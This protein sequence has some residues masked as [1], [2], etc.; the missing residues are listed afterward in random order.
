MEIWIIVFL[1]VWVLANV[2]WNYRMFSNN[3][4]VCIGA[5]FQG[6]FAAVPN[7]VVIFSEWMTEKFEFWTFPIFMSKELREDVA[8]VNEQYPNNIMVIHEADGKEVHF[9]A[10]QVDKLGKELIE[11]VKKQAIK[12]SKNKSTKKGKR[13]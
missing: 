12:D 3:G 1:V 10:E 11:E 9:T 6:I 5:I 2:I 8:F 4:F 7:L 13:K